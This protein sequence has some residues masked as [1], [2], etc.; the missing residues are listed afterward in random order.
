MLT[1]W[2]RP[3]RPAQGP[4]LSVMNRLSRNTMLTPPAALATRVTTAMGA[5]IAVIAVIAELN[6]C[7]PAPLIASRL[8]MFSTLPRTPRTLASTPSRPR[9]QSDRPASSQGGVQGCELNIA[10]QASLKASLRITLAQ[11][12]QGHQHGHAPTMQPSLELFAV[13]R[14]EWAKPPYGSTSSTP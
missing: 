3:P 12:A 13:S 14:T 6:Q 2:Q 11:P 10:D 1:P 9:A 8:L 5:P 7:C 4:S